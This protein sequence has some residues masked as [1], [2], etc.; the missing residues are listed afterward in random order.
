M[1]LEKVGLQFLMEHTLLIYNMSFEV[2][3][4]EKTARVRY[5][6]AVQT[7]MEAHVGGETNSLLSGVVI[8]LWL[9]L[10]TVCGSELRNLTFRR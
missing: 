6:C 4:Y 9:I 10:Y 5:N 8:V 3:S 1:N 7:Q 2:S